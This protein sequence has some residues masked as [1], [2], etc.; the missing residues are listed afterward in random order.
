MSLAMNATTGAPPPENSEARITIDAA[1][2]PRGQTKPNAETVVG[3][4]VDDKTFRTVRA[5]AACRG[6]RVDAVHAGPGRVSFAVN[7]W[8]LTRDCATLV[9]VRALLARMGVDA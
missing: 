9:D 5:V 8:G 3:V 7:R 1:P 6:T 2:G 4:K